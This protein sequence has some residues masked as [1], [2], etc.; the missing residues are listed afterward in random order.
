[1]SLAPQ[2]Q[3]VRD[4]LHPMATTLRDSTN[5]KLD[6][7]VQECTKKFVKAFLDKYP[8]KKQEVANL[9]RSEYKNLIENLKFGKHSHFWRKNK[10]LRD[11][12][13]FLR[14]EEKILTANFVTAQVNLKYNGQDIIFSGKYSSNPSTND[15]DLDFEP[16]DKAQ[17]AVVKATKKPGVDKPSLSHTALRPNAL[18]PAEFYVADTDRVRLLEDSYL[19]GTD[20][21]QWGARWR[22]TAPQFSNPLQ[23]TPQ[24]RQKLKGEL[25]LQS[26][27][28][29]IKDGDYFYEAGIRSCSESSFLSQLWHHLEKADPRAFARGKAPKDFSGLTGTITLFSETKPCNEV[30]ARRITE[31]TRE[32]TG[33]DVTVGYAFDYVMKAVNSR[34]NGVLTTNLKFFE[35]ES[36]A[37]VTIGAS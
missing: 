7:H 3:V 28:D 17:D 20:A 37:E 33:V 36:V 5:K 13:S 14:K 23:M 4:V 27:L 29:Q 11:L 32:M 18:D 31:M 21:W 24:L 6:H 25:Y 1:V 22:D 9:N 34:K 35:A 26:T 30:C 16:A 12:D 10:Q 15:L 8:E 2:E 19:F